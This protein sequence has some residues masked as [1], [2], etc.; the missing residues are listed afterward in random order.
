MRK[1]SFPR[2]VLVGMTNTVVGY[3]LILLLHYGAGVGPVSA[4]IGGYLIGALLSYV[5]NRRFAFASDR[6]HTEALPRFGLAVAGCFAINLVVLKIC[7]SVLALPVALA[8]A[9][10]VS[11]YTVTFYLTCRFLVFRT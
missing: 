11:A 2:F 7:V 9:L 1:S 10:A 8:Q 4:N 3:G 5:L 6:P